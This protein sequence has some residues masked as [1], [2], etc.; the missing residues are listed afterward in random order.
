[1][2]FEIL[3]PHNFTVQFAQNF[4]TADRLYEMVSETDA[5]WVSATDSVDNDSDDARS[6]HAFSE[7]LH[8][9][10]PYGQRRPLSLSVFLANKQFHSEAAA[11][12]YGRNRFRFHISRRPHQPVN[13]FKRLVPQVAAY[14]KDI[15]IVIRDS[16]HDWRAYRRVHEDLRAIVAALCDTNYHQRTRLKVDL[17]TV[18]WHDSRSIFAHNE[19]V[20]Y[21]YVL[22]PLADLRNFLNVE[23]VG[24][25]SGQ[26]AVRLGSLTRADATME[27]P[28]KAERKT[29]IVASYKRRQV[30]CKKRVMLRPYYQKEYDWD[31]LEE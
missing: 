17:R 13:T 26:F 19:T 15:E 22:E 24:D 25:I 7:I 3:L 21:Q 1:M 16:L 23:V 10:Y 9:R 14:L 27:K 18:T 29:K 5:Q 8:P 30:T 6:V 28:P 2:M 11:V 12:L 20:K 4:G 31:Q